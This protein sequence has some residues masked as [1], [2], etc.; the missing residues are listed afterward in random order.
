M[1]IAILVNAGNR[2]FFFFNSFSFSFPYSLFSHIP[3][4]E[5]KK[6]KGGGKVESAEKK[7]RDIS[8]SPF[9]RPHLH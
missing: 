8:H 4:W 1:H 2:K 6:R 5:I 3:I 9:N 7:S